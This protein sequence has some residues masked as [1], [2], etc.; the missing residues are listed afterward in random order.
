MRLALRGTQ[1]Y[2]L[3][4]RVR[5]GTT[6]LVSSGLL[7]SVG[8]TGLDVTQWTRG[9]WVVLS[10]AGVVD[11]ATA[12]LSE[13]LAVVLG[14]GANKLVCDLRGVS[15]FDAAGVRRR[16]IA[17]VD[18][19]SVFAIRA[20]AAGVITTQARYHDAMGR[21]G[22]TDSERLRQTAR[23]R[24]RHVRYV[25][26][27]QRQSTPAAAPIG[28]AVRGSHE[29][30]W[31]RDLTL[32]STIRL[33]LPSSGHRSGHHPRTDSTGRT[34]GVLLLPNM[35]KTPRSTRVAVPAD[36]KWP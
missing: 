33:P 11:I 16:V 28:R 32:G 27:H 21:P 19:E 24:W 30:G 7:G 3:N 31:G 4:P 1:P 34:R 25:A 26:E 2:N 14:A 6:A 8:S 18:L 23:T 12:E 10:I 36:R 9:S 15:F 17:L 22:H 13:A 35:S 29:R 20:S 5:A